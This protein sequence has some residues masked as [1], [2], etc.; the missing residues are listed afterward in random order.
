MHRSYRRKRDQGSPWL[1]IMITLILAT[2][3]VYLSYQHAVVNPREAATAMGEA[4]VA[5]TARTAARTAGNAEPRAL[6]HQQSDI[7]TEIEGSL[8]QGKP[9]GEPLAAAFNC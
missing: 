1:L 2:T 5:Q 3:V 9:E 4:R 6:G 8:K 7:S